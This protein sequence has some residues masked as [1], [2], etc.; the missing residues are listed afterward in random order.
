MK[1]AD[2]SMSI[3]FGPGQP[4]PDEPDGCQE[5]FWALFSVEYEASA[6]WQAVKANGGDVESATEVRNRARAAVDSFLQEHPDRAF[7][8][9]KPSDIARAFDSTIAPLF[10][11]DDVPMPADGPTG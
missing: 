1:G 7:L 11:A 2:M 5:R 10:P 6:S 8:V 3:A 9:F 4:P